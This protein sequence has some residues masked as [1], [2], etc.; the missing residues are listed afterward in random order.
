MAKSR[1]RRLTV[2]LH[3]GNN[4][5]EQRYGRVSP[6]LQFMHLFPYVDSLWFGEGFDMAGPGAPHCT[7]PH[8]HCTP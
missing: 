3:S 2:D 6:A 1:G 4:L 5:A 8:P 7:R